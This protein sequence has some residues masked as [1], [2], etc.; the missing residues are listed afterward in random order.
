MHDFA[1][2]LLER[3]QRGEISRRCEARFFREFALGGVQRIFPLHELTLG[4]RPGPIVLLRPERP[5]GMHQKNLEDPE[6]LA[7]E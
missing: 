1:A 2:R 6:V 4:N 5:T 7:V 3:F